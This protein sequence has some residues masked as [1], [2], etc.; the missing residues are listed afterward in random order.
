MRWET[1]CNEENEME[2][3]TKKCEIIYKEHAKANPTTQNEKK[4][5]LLGYTEN[6]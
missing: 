1:N 2:W 5:G 4:W 6:I 3:L